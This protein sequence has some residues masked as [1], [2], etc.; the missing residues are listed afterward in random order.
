[1]V[2][3]IHRIVH[4]DTES[5]YE[6]VVGYRESYYLNRYVV[7]NTRYYYKSMRRSPLI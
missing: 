2:K 5:S 4:R 3:E 1:M 6:S 7:G